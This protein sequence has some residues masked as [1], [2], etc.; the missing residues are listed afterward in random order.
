MLAIFTKR[1][2]VHFQNEALRTEVIIM[3]KNITKVN[4][5]D[6]ILSGGC[7]HTKSF[8]R[9]VGNKALTFLVVGAS[10]YLGAKAQQLKS[11]RKPE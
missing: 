6:L 2:W 8:L 5:D 1:W 11:S 3:K 7:D 9:S 4:D 10:I